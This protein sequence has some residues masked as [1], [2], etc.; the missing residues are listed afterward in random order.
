MKKQTPF[1][2]AT[3]FT[4]AL[5]L[6]VSC[7]KDAGNNALSSTD[8]EQSTISFSQSEADAQL[9]FGDILE[10][11]VGVNS[12]LGTG[13][14][15]IFGRIAE[16]AGSAR[17]DSLPSCVAV[18]I[19]PLQL[20]VFPKTLV[21]DFG[22]GCFSHGHLRS[23]KITTVYTGRLTEVGK[24]ATTTFENFTLDSVQVE[25]THKVTNTTVGATQ[26]RQFTIEITNGKLTHASGAFISWNA[27]RT[28]TQK[29]GNSTLSP[30]DD[31]FS[32]TGNSSGTTNRW[33]NRQLSW[34]TTIQEPLVKRFTCRWL[35][36]GIVKTERT[37]SPSGEQQAGL[38]DFGNGACDN[39]ATLTVNGNVHQIVLR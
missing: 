20:N 38:L 23:G 14:A 29:E 4:V 33:N 17:V 26:Q 10:N 6:F 5:F 16:P 35:S 15:G 37:G 7:K 12:E 30:L 11:V 24:S 34:N 31:A 3:T 39:K 19:A 27:T 8:E 32:L 13:S 22:T 28:H 21:L 18:S 9:I 36:K 1:T 25:G 2:V